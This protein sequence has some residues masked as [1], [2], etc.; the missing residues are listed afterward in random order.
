MRQEH[1]AG[2]L[3][4]SSKSLEMLENKNLAGARDWDYPSSVSRLWIRPWIGVGILTGKPDLG[5][6]TIQS[7]M[8][9]DGRRSNRVRLPRYFVYRA[10]GLANFLR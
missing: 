10:S 4:L 2:Q 6:E 5:I 8:S 7:A 9:R 3:G 1:S